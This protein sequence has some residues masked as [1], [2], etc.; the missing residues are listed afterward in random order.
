VATSGF[1]GELTTVLTHATM[2]M[3]GFAMRHAKRTQW[4]HMPDYRMPAISVNLEKRISTLNSVLTEQ[5][6]QRAVE[7][8]IHATNGDWAAALA[9]LKEVLPAASL[10]KITFAQSLA[11][12][13]DDNVSIVKKLAERPDV[14]S[15][16]DVALHYGAAK[17]A[18]L[19]VRKF[20]ADLAAQ[21]VSGGP[22]RHAE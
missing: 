5:A 4:T 22:H 20:C 9:R 14:T 2:G 6:E 17:L 13:S 11:E 1:G 10:Q 21:A 15:L 18:A 8:E 7:T 3:V 16:R 12:W 19:L